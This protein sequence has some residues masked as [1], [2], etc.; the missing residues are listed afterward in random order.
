M[1]TQPAAR[2]LPEFLKSV[3]TSTADALAAMSDDDIRVYFLA[4][5]DQLDWTATDKRWRS[6]LSLL[7]HDRV[8]RDDDPMRRELLG[9]LV[10]I[11]DQAQEMMLMRVEHSDRED[12]ENTA[13]DLRTA[14]D[15]LH[16]IV[17][18]LTAVHTL[19]SAAS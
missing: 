16:A 7:Q 5:L 15:R 19:G 1:T 17:Y 4:M 13:R 8:W 9:L 6:G 18:A 11:T 14:T 10:Q 3:A 2:D 12:V